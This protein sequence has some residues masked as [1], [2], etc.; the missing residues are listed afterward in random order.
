MNLLSLGT[1]GWTSIAIGALFFQIID[2]FFNRGAFRSFANLYQTDL[3]FG[4]ASVLIVAPIFLIVINVLHKS[5]RKRNLDCNSSIHRGLTY[6]ILLVA[7]LNIIAHLIQ[8]VYQLLNDYYTLA[9]GL[10]I[11]VVLLIASGIFGYYW[12][13]LNRVDYTKRSMVS[14]IFFILV[15]VVSLVSLVSSFSIIDSAQTNRL[16]EYDQQR[17]D[18]LLDLDFLI[19]GYQAQGMLPLDLS[20]SRFTIFKDPATRQPYEYNKIND[21]NYELCA[22]FDVAILVDEPPIKGVIINGI[23]DWYYR[24]DG[25]Q[26][27]AN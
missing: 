20:E 7:A 26:C 15:I 1:L 8:L 6:F 14:I 3:K 5:Y 4:I 11:V 17:L 16:K 24:G 18:D 21:I 25:Y 19:R 22:I 10:K 2:N 12:Y 27:F 23:K 13:D 9:S